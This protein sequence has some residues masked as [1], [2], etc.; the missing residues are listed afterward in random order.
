MAQST[1]NKI[2]SYLK[3]NQYP[4][5]VTVKVS[6]TGTVII[7]NLPLM[8]DVSAIVQAATGQRAEY[9]TPSMAKLT[10]A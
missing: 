6:K 8:S 9:C 3:N 5:H 10:G 7:D 1:R 2:V 4:S